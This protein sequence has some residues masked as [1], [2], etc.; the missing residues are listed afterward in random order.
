MTTTRKTSSIKKVLLITV[1]LCLVLTTLVGCSGGGLS[2]TYKSQG[3]ISQSFTFSGSDKVTMSA[4]GINANGTYKISGNTMTITYSLF[5]FES[6][7]DCKYEKKGSSI[8]ID[9]TEFIKQ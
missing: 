8:Y 9:G 4:F 5:G 3:L 1:A 7:W 2:G 6:S